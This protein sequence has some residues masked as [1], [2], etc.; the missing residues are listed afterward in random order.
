MSNNLDKFF[1]AEE[2]IKIMLNIKSNSL[3]Y[4]DE[5][6]II[7]KNCHYFI[8][9][10]KIEK[11]IFNAAFFT[12]IPKIMQKKLVDLNKY[13]YDVPDDGRRVPNIDKFLDKIRKSNNYID[14]N[15]LVLEMTNMVYSPKDIELC[16]KEL[17]SLLSKENIEIILKVPNP[18]KLIGFYYDAFP[19]EENI[20]CSM[21][22]CP[23]RAT[24]GPIFASYTHCI[25][26][27]ERHERTDIAPKCGDIQCK[28]KGIYGE[29]ISSN[30]FYCKAH[31]NSEHKNL[32][33]SPCS[34]CGA[35]DDCNEQLCQKC[36]KIF[37]DKK[38]KESMVQ[39]LLDVN[40]IPYESRDKRVEDGN[41]RRRPDFIIDCSSWKIILEVDERQHKHYKPK[42]EIL[43]M[44][45][46]FH[47]YD[48]IPILF[49]RYNP[50]V[51]VSHTG[52]KV[53]YDHSRGSALIKY[54]KQ[55]MNSEQSAK[56]LSVVYMF[57]DKY[58]TCNIIH[59]ID[60]NNTN[61]DDIL[62]KLNRK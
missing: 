40:N 44:I 18:D 5:I 4:A 24:Y 10:W 45:Q 28:E 52:R 47:D 7:S 53:K 1:T 34:F 16:I 12:G 59:E 29:S 9:R 57:Y 58:D 21:T 56:H 55:L 30:Y 25:R 23:F 43:R 13:V 37:H 15:T 11:M 14:L 35:Q 27:A 36:F 50:D 48:E 41:S 62:T 6:D 54:I 31:A 51:Y 8:E 49:V 32:M 33:G 3:H 22:D 17:L 61:V 38:R 26:H 19:E 39:S 2:S 60:Y 42:D 20:M 46:I